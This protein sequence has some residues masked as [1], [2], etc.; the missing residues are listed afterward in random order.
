[1]LL[2]L[3]VLE[4]QSK[5]GLGADENAAAELIIETNL[6]AAQEQCLGIE[7]EGVAD[8]IEKLPPFQPRPKFPPM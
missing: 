3:V 1:V 8:G 5:F 4:S 2:L 6:C 7:A